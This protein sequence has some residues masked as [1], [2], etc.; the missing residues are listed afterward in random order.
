[1]LKG[2]PPLFTELPRETVRKAPIYSELKPQKLTKRTY[3]G[4]LLN[5]AATNLCT[6]GEVLDGTSRGDSIALWG[7]SSRSFWPI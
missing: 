4:S 6:I 2:L 3:S 1:M 7:S 5:T